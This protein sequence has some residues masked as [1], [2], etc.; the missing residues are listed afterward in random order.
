MCREVLH[1]FHQYLSFG[2]DRKKIGGADTVFGKLHNVGGCAVK[3]RRGLGGS[4]RVAVEVEV[5]VEELE[6]ELEDE[7]EVVSRRTSIQLGKDLK[8]HK[9]P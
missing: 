1:N 5:E 3:C 4:E 7:D 8:R 2:K 9:V 6:L